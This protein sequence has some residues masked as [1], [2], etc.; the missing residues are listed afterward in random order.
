MAV[1]MAILS[2]SSATI[3]PTANKRSKATIYL[4]EDFLKSVKKH[5]IDTG[6][7][8]SAFMASAAAA[9]LKHD[10]SRTGRKKLA[11]K[12]SADSL[13]DIIADIAKA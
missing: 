12:R 8:L 4:D 7:T 5:I 3:T 9:K 13:D 11:A 6:E 2:K 10:Q 1:V